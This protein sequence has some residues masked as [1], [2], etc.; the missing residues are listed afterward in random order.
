RLLTSTLFP[1]TDALP[2]SFR[3]EAA[4]SE[5]FA[6]VDIID[7]DDTIPESVVFLATCVTAQGF[8]TTHGYLAAYRQVVPGQFGLVNVDLET[9]SE[10]HTSELQSPDHLVC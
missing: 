8:L 5:F 3:Q 10:E 2:I 7:W 4:Y 6:G 9:R 1:Y